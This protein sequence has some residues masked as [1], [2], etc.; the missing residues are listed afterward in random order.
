MKKYTT[1]NDDYFDD[2]DFEHA[3]VIK[4]PMIVQLQH[5]KKAYEKAS[6]EV[7]HKLDADVVDLINTHTSPK[8]IERLNT[9]IRAL[10]A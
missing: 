4:H 1:V 3:K 9:V 5:N 6:L 7:L 8:D 2:F 10:F